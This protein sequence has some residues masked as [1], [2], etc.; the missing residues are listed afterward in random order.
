[1]SVYKRGAL[2]HYDFQL[3]HVRHTSPAG[4]TDKDDAVDAEATLK[5]RLKRRAAG[6]EPLDAIDTP[7]FTDWAGITLKWQTHRKQ[8]KDPEAM[9]NT[10]RMILAFWGATPTQT[11]PVP[12]GVYKDLRLGHPI[13]QPELIE[14]F[15][16][17]M[18][19]RKLSGARKN[20]YR[21]ACSMLYRVALLPGNRTRAG[22]RENPFAGILRDRVRR[23]TATLTPEQLQ[24]WLAA[25]DEPTMIAVALGTLSP[26]LRLKNVVD[27]TRADFT[28]TRD[29]LSVPHKTDRTTGL[30]L[31]IAVSAQLQR[32]LVAIEQAHP[33]DPYIVPLTGERYWQLVKRIK[34]SI[35]AAGLPYGR[36]HPHG[37]TFHSLR[38]SVSTWLARWG[39]SAAESQRALGHETEQMAAWYRHLAGADTVRPMALIGE[40]VDVETTVVAKLSG[41]HT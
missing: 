39:A 18:T 11:P 12:G 17:W 36:K 27:L 15:E 38:H 14:E 2:W 25:A 13:A 35:Q 19:S 3:F 40:R 41:S 31:T 29:F 10:Y 9:K 34:A 6:L 4:F 16:D 24:A 28:P 1:M 33:K 22:V 30:P 7:R 21:S 32:I 26:A 5:R 8:I 23:R 37:I 20:H